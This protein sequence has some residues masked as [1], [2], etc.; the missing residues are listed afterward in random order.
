MKKLLHP[1]SLSLWTVILVF[2]LPFVVPD[3]VIPQ[4]NDRQLREA[5]LSRKMLP[6]PKTYEALLEVV[7]NPNN[8]MSRAKIALGKQL[9]F[10]TRLSR[11]MTLNC[12]SCHILEQGGD[13]NRPTAIG[14]HGRENPFHLNSPTVLNATLQQSQFWNGSAAD[15]EEQAGGPVQAPFEMNMTPTEVEARLNADAALVA[16]FGKI[17]G[18]SKISFGDVRNAIGAYERTLLTRGAYDRFLDG[19]DDA[20]NAQAKRGMTLFI[21]RGCKA[22]HRDMALGG[23]SIEKF[24]LR[25]YFMD[26]VGVVLDPNMQVNDNPFPF[27]NKGGFLGRDNRQLFKVPVLRNIT[28]TSPYFHNGSVEEIE[29]VVRLMSKYQLGDEFSNEQID[30]VVAFLKTLEGALVVY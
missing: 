1:V 7:D 13:D 19:E 15:V 23:Q 4:W 9:F 16:T 27:E 25:R 18:S 21:S 10:D 5:A 2:M 11:D 6:V 14:F 22:C 28:Q 24:P 20:I 17:F 26:Y 30:D 3:R 8:P 12:A 29:E